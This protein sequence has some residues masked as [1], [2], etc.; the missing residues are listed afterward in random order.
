MRKLR[1]TGVVLLGLGILGAHVASN[2]ALYLSMMSMHDQLRLQTEESTNAF[3]STE[4]RGETHQDEEGGMNYF[5]IPVYV[6]PACVTW[7]LWGGGIVI[8]LG[9]VFLA[10]ASRRERPMSEPTQEPPNTDSRP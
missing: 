10:V 5:D 2:A 4:I 3:G 6:P 1:L 8:I 7:H 9:T